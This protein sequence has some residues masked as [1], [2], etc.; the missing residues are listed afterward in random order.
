VTT[1]QHRLFDVLRKAI[2]TTRDLSL[3]AQRGDGDDPFTLL[4]TMLTPAQ[5]LEAE[6]EA[7]LS[8]ALA[9]LLEQLKPCQQLAI[10]VCYQFDN[11]EPRRGQRNPKYRRDN[12]YHAMSALREM[13]G[14]PRP[15]RS[16]QS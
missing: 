15:Q 5:R 4:Q 11:W 2:P 3:D 13:A 14:V 9:A 1:A 16:G 10:Q 7:L 6:P 12:L 8:P